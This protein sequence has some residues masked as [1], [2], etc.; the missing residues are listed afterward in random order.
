MPAVTARPFPS[1][2]TKQVRPTT[3]APELVAGDHLTRAEFERRYHAMPDLKKAELVEGRVF[4]GSPVRINQHGKPHA[5]L[6][7]WLV[8]YQ[9]FTPGV[10]IADNATV[11]LDHDNEP[12]P[13][14]LLRILPE[15]GGQS[16]NEGDYV[17]G[18][19]EFVA[20]I[21]GSSASYD[22]YEKK[23]AYRRNGVREYCVWLVDEAEI[24]WWRLLD[25]D[26][27][28][29]EPDEA[30][31]LKSETFPGLWL[32]PTALLTGDLARVLDL[33]RA[34]TASPEHADFVASLRGQSPEET[35]PA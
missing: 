3:P 8:Q 9:A 15:Y 18:A 30:G 7:G 19:P 23:T 4:M 29:I 35:T 11:R 13:D 2:E 33:A 1:L 5:Q 6:A 10:E 27:V 28:M 16:A 31:L 22:L 26:Y 21:A 25:G 12:Q 32:D 20:E 34:G 17:S 14:L 24:R